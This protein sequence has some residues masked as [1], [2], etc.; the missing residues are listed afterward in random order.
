MD[1]NNLNNANWG[2]APVQ[3]P[4]AGRGPVPAQSSQGGAWGPAPVQ[5]PQVGRGPVPAQPP[6]S[7]S[8]AWGTPPVQ[9]PQAGRGQVPAQSSQGGA[10]GPAPVQQPQTNSAH[11]SHNSTVEYYP[12]PSEGNM[13]STSSM[14]V[15]NPYSQATSSQNWGPDS[16]FQAGN[17]TTIPSDVSRKKKKVLLGVAA[18]LFVL[19]ALLFLIVLGLGLFFQFSVKPIDDTTLYREAGY[20][21][22]IEINDVLTG[23]EWIT[24]MSSIDDGGLNTD[25][26]GEYDVVVTHG[27]KKYAFTAIVRDT[28]P[29][30]LKLVDTPIYVKVS[31]GNVSKDS[32]ISTVSDKGSKVTTYLEFANSAIKQKG[33]DLYFSKVGDFKVTVCAEDEY[34]N[35]SKK[36]IVITSDTA[37]AIIG[38]TS[39]YVVPGSKINILDGVSAKD[40]VDGKVE[41][42]YDKDAFNIA[43]AGEY[44]VKLTATDSYGL[45]TEEEILVVVES[46]DKIQERI[47]KHEISRFDDRI[48]GAYNIYDRGYSTKSNIDDTLEYYQNAFV[49]I[50]EGSMNSSR[51]RGSGYIVKITDDEI[52]IMT[53]NHVAYSENKQFYV[54]FY[55]ET[56][57][58]A[59]LVARS[60]ETCTKDDIA[61]LSVNLE[62]VPQKLLDT[63]YTIHIDKANYDAAK[64][65]S[66]LDIGM[67]VWKDSFN[68]RPTKIST[69]KLVSKL[70]DSHSTAGEAMQ[71]TVGLYPGC[72]G[73][74]VIDKNGNLIGMATFTVN[75]GSNKTNWCVPFDRVLLFY[76]KT[77]NE[78]LNYK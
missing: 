78:K 45:S 15:G 1:K 72:S 19:G 68:M 49:A 33:D 6:Q 4:Q 48:I 55:D 12:P 28:L 60:N 70:T 75:S 64:E 5:Q 63:L 65:G 36:E 20:P 24:K 23:P 8:S 67:K 37:P 59:K 7:S 56:R 44:P 21:G 3:Q 10:W 32:L 71:V 62:D 61:I 57:I 51:S 14:N 46:A 50:T 35:I 25:V 38:L 52:R 13:G 34:K 74:A 31:T 54:E 40:D 9:Q 77:Y 2:P 30:E 76:E 53:N 41:V 16:N 47:N 17:D 43:Q 39:Y 69:G 58:A 66:T 26:I 18:T 22:S 29:P 27:F 73:S 42:K 11:S